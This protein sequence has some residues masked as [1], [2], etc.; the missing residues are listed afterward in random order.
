VIGDV[1]FQKLVYAK[2]QNNRVTLARYKR[3]GISL[4]DVSKALSVK[5]KIDDTQMLNPSK[6]TVYADARKIFCY[7]AH[8][9]G[10]PTLDIGNFLGIQQAAV[11]HASRKGASLA[12]KLSI[13]IG[14]EDSIV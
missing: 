10:F 2:A 12:E 14:G 3:E 9:A 5:M 4:E 7:L 1:A 6:R 11:S 13:K 8:A